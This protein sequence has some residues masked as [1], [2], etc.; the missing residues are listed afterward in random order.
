MC[1]GEREKGVRLGLEVTCE[2]WWRADMPMAIVSDRAAATA[3][4]GSTLH[5]TMTMTQ[6]ASAK[7]VN[8]T[9]CG[10]QEANCRGRKENEWKG[11]EWEVRAKNCCWVWYEVKGDES[12]GGDGGV[13]G[14]RR[15]RMG[16][17]AGTLA[18]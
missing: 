10:G 17:G 7:L 16:A 9:A 13:D 11:S 1:G 2:P 12:S 14:D 15:T 4:S 5:P 18:Q 6:G 8:E 3:A